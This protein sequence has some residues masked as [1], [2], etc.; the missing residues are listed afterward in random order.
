MFHMVFLKR[1]FMGDYVIDRYISGTIAIVAE[2]GEDINLLES[3]EIMNMIVG[4]S[5]CT[6]MNHSK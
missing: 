5:S 1:C 4:L 2:I 6:S 3:A